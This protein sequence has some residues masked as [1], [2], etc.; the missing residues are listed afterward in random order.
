MVDEIAAA[1]PYLPKG[2]PTSI[3]REAAHDLIR[4]SITIG[5]HRRTHC[6]V[7]VRAGK[8]PR[9]G[10]SALRAVALG[11]VHGRD[12]RDVPLRVLKGATLR[13]AA[14]RGGQESHGG[15]RWAGV[16]RGREVG[17]S[18]ALAHE[19]HGGARWAGVLRR[20]EEGTSEAL[21]HDSHGGAR[22]ARVR[23]GRTTPTAA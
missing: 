10:D 17:T 13:P 2:V 4:V 21:A 6:H 14:T 15:A 5:G 18:E 7:R 8:H 1:K 11:D 20:R 3:W 12:G 19:S 9:G 23:P 22:R 16:P